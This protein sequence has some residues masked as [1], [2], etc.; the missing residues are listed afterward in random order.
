ML[1]NGSFA[2]AQSLIPFFDRL[3]A[4]SEEARLG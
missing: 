1:A 3:I 2:V 4:G